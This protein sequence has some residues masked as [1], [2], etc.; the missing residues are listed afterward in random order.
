MSDV[1]EIRCSSLP[2]LLSCAAS[3]VP[4]KTR[5]ESGHAAARLGSAFHEFI[6]GV[7]SGDEQSLADV[8]AKHV[9]DMEELRPMALWA[10]SLWLEQLKY[11]FPLAISEKQ[12]VAYVAG[13]PFRLTGHPDLLGCVNTEVRGLDWKTGYI[14]EDVTDQ[15]RGYAWLGMHHWPDAESARMTVLR[16]REQQADTF[17]F[18]RVELELWWDHVCKHLSDPSVF[19]AG[20]WCGFC[21]RS[22]ECPEQRR[23]LETLL[24]LV[25]AGQFEVGDSEPV[26]L[27]VATAWAKEIIRGLELFILAAK[28]QV[29]SHGGEYGPM[30][31]KTQSRRAIDVYRGF[32]VLE[33]ALGRERFLGMLKIGIG[34]VQ[35]AVKDAAPRGNKMNALRDLNANLELVGAM[36]TTWIE[37]LE[38]NE[39]G[40][41]DARRLV[42]ASNQNNDAATTGELRA[43]ESAARPDAGQRDG[44]HEI[45]SDQRQPEQPN[46]ASRGRSARKPQ[47]P[48][49]AAY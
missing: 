24:S 47:G 8:A 15:L 38:V 21:P 29:V 12:L 41:N 14:A 20:S 33:K 9:V 10:R 27:A 2:R 34:E 13:W 28:A 6:S 46:S 19:S 43:D 25:P 4:P 42:A 39:R 3:S 36:K 22:H 44:Q 48:S 30:S 17:T 40:I 5:V 35:E 37:K 16:V 32:D 31:I 7:I 23:R 45:A 11:S 49:H 1:P 26:K 18:S